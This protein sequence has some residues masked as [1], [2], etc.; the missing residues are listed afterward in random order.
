MAI[1][2]QHSDRQ[3]R[4]S[5]VLRPSE[6]AIVRRIVLT[7]L[8]AWG[9]E[10]EADDVLTVVNELLS[11]VVSHVPGAQCNLT[12]ERKAYLLHVRVSDASRA[13][14]TRQ[15]PGADRTTGRGLALV[16]ALT[17]GYW[18]VMPPPL[19]GKGK[20]I[21]CLFDIS[22]ATPPVE[23]AKGAD[24]VREIFRYGLAHPNR[25]PDIIRY[26]CAACDHL[27]TGE[28]CT[29][30]CLS[31]TVGSVARSGDLVRLLNGA[32]TRQDSSPTAAARR[33]TA[34]GTGLRLEPGPTAA[35]LWIEQRR[36]D[37]QDQQR[38]RERLHFWY[39][40][41]IPPGFPDP[42]RDGS[43]WTPVADL[44]PAPLRDLIPTAALG[45]H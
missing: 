26:T 29:Q 31:V 8:H 9:L 2:T 1:H 43:S 37:L 36:P 19:G 16:D 44:S 27:A 15:Q 35:P 20:E 24:V 6:L 11:N 22:R 10:S 33:I 34:K 23:T 17:H 40:F 39:L 45:R 28:P 13:M 5:L 7:Q 25:L 38:Q 18:K 21:H 42:Q 3:L 12:L 41:E 30:R 4:M 14:P 32:L